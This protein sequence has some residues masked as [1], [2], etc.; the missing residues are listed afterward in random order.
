M[1]LPSFSG[2][3]EVRRRA[4]APGFGRNCGALSAGERPYNGSGFLC[5]R[6]EGQLA[7]NDVQGFYVIE[8]ELRGLIVHLLNAMLVV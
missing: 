2:Q 5:V 3:I 8:S 6:L 1:V 7:P 4:N